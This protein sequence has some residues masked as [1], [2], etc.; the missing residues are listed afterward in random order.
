MALATEQGKHVALAALGERRAHPPEKIV[1]SQLPA[2]SPMFYYCRACG[3]LADTLPE[4]WWIRPP[5][6]LCKECQA[7]ADCGWLE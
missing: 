7:L 6:K 1:N 4:N 2:G 5:A 3:H